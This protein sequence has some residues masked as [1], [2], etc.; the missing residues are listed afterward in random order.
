MSKCGLCEDRE[1]TNLV[2]VEDEPL[3]LCSVCMS[4]INEGRVLTGKQ[5]IGGAAGV[6]PADL[7]PRPASTS[8]APPQWVEPPAPVS[9]MSPEEVDSAWRGATGLRIATGLSLALPFLVNAA[10]M[11]ICFRPGVQGSAPEWLKPASILVPLLAPAVL[12]GVLSHRVGRNAGL[13]VLLTLFCW[14]LPAPL[15]ALLKPGWTRRFESDTPFTP[16]V[17]SG[18]MSDPS[19][20]V[21][22]PLPT[23][24]LVPAADPMDTLFKQAVGAVKNPGLQGG[25]ALDEI[26]GRVM[27]PGALRPFVASLQEVLEQGHESDGVVARRAATF[28]CQACART[29]AALFR[30]ILATIRQSG[31][32]VSGGASLEQAPPVDYDE[33]R[34]GDFYV[35]DLFPL[36]SAA[37]TV[38]ERLFS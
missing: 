13:C 34:C 14:G 22:D 31:G 2:L 1:G 25:G 24:P 27:A 15:L 11:Y 36:L 12:A 7:P 35:D 16:S 32:E 17:A 37:G 33:I 4:V 20:P 23:L 29:S 30:E 10:V 18:S 9:R 26:K 6:V 28:A 19:P 8:T 38:K 5:A 21:A 3:W